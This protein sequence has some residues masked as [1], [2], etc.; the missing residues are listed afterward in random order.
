MFF[1]VLDAQE[2]KKCIDLEVVAR[3]YW[4]DSPVPACPVLQLVGSE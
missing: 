2:M 3:M 1:S 4:S